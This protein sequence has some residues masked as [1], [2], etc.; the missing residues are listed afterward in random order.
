MHSH[1]TPDAPRR[2]VANGTVS[3]HGGETDRGSARVGRLERPDES[4]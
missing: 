1:L 4:A 3:I 2:G